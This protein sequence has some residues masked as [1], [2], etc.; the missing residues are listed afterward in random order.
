MKFCSVTCNIINIL[1]KKGS[2]LE[3][4][5]VPATVFVEYLFNNSHF[6]AHEEKENN[7]DTT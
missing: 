3:S 7:D 1:L 5:A 2:L 6:H 4:G